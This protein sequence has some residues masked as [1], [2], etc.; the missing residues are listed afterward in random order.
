MQHVIFALFRRPREAMD[1]LRQLDQEFSIDDRVKVLVGDADTPSSDLA[2][3]ETHAGKALLHGA[4]Y[5]LVSGAVVGLVAALVGLRWFHFDGSTAIFAPIAGALFGG[6]AAVLFGS[7][8]PDPSL[9]R[10]RRM[11]R[12]GG[13]IITVEAE[14]ETRT[15]RAAEILKQNHGYLTPAASS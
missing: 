1:A 4:L 8:N 6:F 11:A 9:S 10:L 13:V 7:I 14:D 12:T 3:A 5:G 15:H 2:M